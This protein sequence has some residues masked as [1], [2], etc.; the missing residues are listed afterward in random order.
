MC[1]QHGLQKG[2]PDSRHEEAEHPGP[3][4]AT[5]GQEQYGFGAGV[6]GGLVICLAC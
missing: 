2:V 6:V 4:Q 1:G 3:H 5:S